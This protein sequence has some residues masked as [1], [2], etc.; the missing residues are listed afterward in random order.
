[1]LQSIWFHLVVIPGIFLLGRLSA[2]VKIAGFRAK[3]VPSRMKNVT[4]NEKETV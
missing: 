3:K 1:M 2:T 4:T